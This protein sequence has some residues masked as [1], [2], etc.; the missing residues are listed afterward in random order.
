MP[1]PSPWWT[2]VWTQNASPPPPPPSGFGVSWVQKCGSTKIWQ[3]IDKTLQVFTDTYFL[4]T[5]YVIAG[6]NQSIR[7]KHAMFKSH[8][9]NVN[10]HWIVCTGHRGFKISLSR[11]L[12]K[13]MWAAETERMMLQ[14]IHGIM[15]DSISI[16]WSSFRVTFVASTIGCQ[17]S[18]FTAV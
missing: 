12:S 16:V 2:W 3:I 17:L 10:A 7:I 5:F 11:G 8:W 18:L 14:N 4:F 6:G 1:T 15:F 9:V 13:H